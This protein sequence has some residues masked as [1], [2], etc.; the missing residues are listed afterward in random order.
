MFYDE[1][2]D[3]VA[4]TK[5]SLY[6][7]SIWLNGWLVAFLA[8]RHAGRSKMDRY[9]DCLV[10]WLLSY[11]MTNVLWEIPWVIV[12]ERTDPVMRCQEMP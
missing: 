7:I 9:H 12:L 8:Q 11:A 10:V 3:F 4:S 6:G 5:T 2:L 1:A